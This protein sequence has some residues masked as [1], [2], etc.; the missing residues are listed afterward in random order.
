MMI[1]NEL[2]WAF[3]MLFIMKSYKSHAVNRE[4]SFNVRWNLIF[5]IFA[6]GLI[7]DNEI[8]VNILITI[9]W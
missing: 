3:F 5:S 8:I 4:G 7:S 2:E 1:M 9:K 6:D